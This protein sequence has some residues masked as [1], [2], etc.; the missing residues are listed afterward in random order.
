MKTSKIILASVILSTG[1]SAFAQ[2]PGSEQDRGLATRVADEL[3]KKDRFRAIDVEA[4]DGI[5][6]LSGN[7]DLYIDKLDAEK[8]VRKMQDVES[9]LNYIDVK[10]AGAED[11]DLREVLAD[12]LRYDR[13]GQG[14][15]FNNLTVAVKDGQ[16]TLGGTVR[17]Y[18]DRN[19]A[20]AIVETTP[21]VKDVLDEVEV[22]PLSPSD[23][24]LRVR[25]ARAIYGHENLRRYANDPQA[26]IR[27]VVKNGNVE[28]HGVVLSEA[29]RTIAYTVA[30]SAPGVFSVENNIVIAR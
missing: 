27:I 30:N 29:D 11:A 4:G 20:L 8:R 19:S 14:I 12:R 21:G 18:P 13:I 5:V 7:V 15:V 28:L 26:P 9:V 6:T 23:D 10:S 2:E 16:V 22:A 25:L 17:D 24:M 1:L 3:A